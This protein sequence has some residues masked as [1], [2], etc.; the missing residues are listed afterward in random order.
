MEYTSC[1]DI[2]FSL[3]SKGMKGSLHTIQQLSK[4]CGAPEKS[5]KSIHVAGTN[6]KGSVVTKI[7]AS[8][9]KEGYRVGLYTSPHISSYRERICING[10]MISKE[11]VVRGLE[12]LFS[13]GIEA[14][15]FEYT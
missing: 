7:A 6:G 5:F 10:E 1:L 11:E 4:A 3:R 13:L 14:S 9:A 15:F 2:L 12:K 8:L